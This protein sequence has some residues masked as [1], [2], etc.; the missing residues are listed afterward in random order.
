MTTPKIPIGIRTIETTNFRN[1]E[2]LKLDFT[3]A[4]GG[5]SEIVVIAGPNGCGKTAVLEACLF[6]LGFRGVMDKTT[7]MQSIRNGA[8]S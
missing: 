3:G 7:V 2:H 4:D 8:D 5:P 6:A 1:I